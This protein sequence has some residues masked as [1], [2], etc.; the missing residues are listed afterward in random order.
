MFL[1][2]SRFG[3]QGTA[4]LPFL[5]AMSM[6][7]AAD[8]ETYSYLEIVEAEATRAVQGGTSGWRNLHTRDSPFWQ[9]QAAWL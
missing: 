5:S 8:G 6:L 2:V 7:G 9:M 4:R 3:R 1:F